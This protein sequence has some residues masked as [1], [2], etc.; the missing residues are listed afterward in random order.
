MPSCLAAGA[1]ERQRWQVCVTTLTGERVRRQIVIL[2]SLLALPL[3]IAAVD[4]RDQTVPVVAIDVDAR[5]SGAR[6]T[7]ISVSPWNAT[8]A[9]GSNVSWVIN[10]AANT[11]S[12]LITPKNVT[13][14]L[15]NAAPPY[16]GRKNA[17]A[18]ASRMKPGVRGR[19]A[20]SI[21]L[22]CRAGAN[23]DTILIDPD[24]IVD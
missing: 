1:G 9:R 7:R 2:G 24:I 19:F 5:C 11:D 3:A 10:A 21:S 8:V 13:T 17:P 14:W 15:Y 12:I 18:T 16:K 4:L 22:I 23:V 20:Y 6:N